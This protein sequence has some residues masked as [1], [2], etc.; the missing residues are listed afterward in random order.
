[1][2]CTVTKENIKMLKSFF[3]EYKIEIYH[4]VR[5][6]D[7]IYKSEDLVNLTGRKFNGQRNHIN[8][9]KKTYP[10]Y[11]FDDINCDNVN[12]VIEFYKSSNLIDSKS[13]AIFIEEQRK[14][15]E[16]LENYGKYGLLGGALKINGAV[17]GFV[18]GETAGNTLYVHIEKANSHYRGAYQMLVNEFAKRYASDSDSS[19]AIEFINREEDDG[20]EGLRISKLSYQPCGIIEKHTATVN[21]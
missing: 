12:Q 11:A 8:Y 2:F 7:Y 17:I 21:I 20:D 9:F 1:M 13:G 6:N 18:I 19:N 3:Y 10:D 16:V 15:F 4:D 14:T 5:W